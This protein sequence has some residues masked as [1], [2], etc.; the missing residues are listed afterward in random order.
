MTVYVT[1]IL[2]GTLFGFVARVIML[3]T[4]YR[5]YPTYRH[6]KVIHLALGFIA[7]GMGAVAVPALKENNYT[8]ITFLAMA[9]QQFRD[10]RNMER[11][12]LSQLDG[13]ELVPRGSAYIEGIAMVFEGRNYLVIFTAFLTSLGV[14]WFNIWVGLLLGTI[15]LLVDLW[16][17]SGHHLADIARVKEGEIRI[18]GE[19]L[20]VNQI[21]LMNVGLVSNREILEKHAVGLVIEPK[22]LDSAVTLANLGQRQA[23]L[24]DAS[25]ILGVYRDSGEPALVP[26][27]K[28]DMDT[29]ELGVLLLPQRREMKKAI[30]VVER[31][32]VLE[33][34]LRLPKEAKVN[35]GKE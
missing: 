34:A 6:G 22:N 9:A 32:P 18:E 1:A 25:V 4:D 29:G 21:Y 33:T 31:V 14:V 11:E 24:H 13:M 20:Y 12:T 16:F 23:I 26:L 7:A 28:R 10:V 35:G 30:Q 3:R 15:S 27:I 5:Q 8:A 17:M 2:S 19:S